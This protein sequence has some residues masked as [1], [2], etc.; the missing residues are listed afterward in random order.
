LTNNISTER[1]DVLKYLAEFDMEALRDLFYQSLTGTLPS[2]QRYHQCIYAKCKYENEYGE[3][4]SCDTC[5][6]SMINVYAL[7]KIMD[8]Y[9][10][11]MKNKAKKY[12]SATIEEKQQP[13]NQSQLCKE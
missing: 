11:I 10:L 9:I 4:P 3:R 13:A 12:N 1:E 5:A 7:E 2:K 8:H 6:A